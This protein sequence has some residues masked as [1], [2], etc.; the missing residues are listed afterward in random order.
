M[1]KESPQSG[2][3]LLTKLINAALRLRYVPVA[4]K[5]ANVIMIFEAREGCGGRQLI[6]LYLLALYSS[7]D[8]DE[9]KPDWEGS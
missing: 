9:K 6:P 5:R 7:K 1:I 4:W 2:M 3:I 8:I